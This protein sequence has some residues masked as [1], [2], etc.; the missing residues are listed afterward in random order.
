[1]RFVGGNEKQFLGQEFVIF[2]Q[3]SLMENK[4]ISSLWLTYSV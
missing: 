2:P 4:I 1:V 3:T